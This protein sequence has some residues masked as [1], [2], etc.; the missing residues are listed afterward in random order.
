MPAIRTNRALLE[1]PFVD[2]PG[3]VLQTYTRHCLVDHPYDI[4][5]RGT[6]VLLM[7]AFHYY[8]GGAGGREE[9]RRGTPGVACFEGMQARCPSRPFSPHARLS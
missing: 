3:S 2:G 9:D 8:T 7:R 6:A 1:C 5:Y 4:R